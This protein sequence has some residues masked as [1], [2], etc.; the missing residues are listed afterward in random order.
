[1]NT[2]QWKGLANNMIGQMQERVGALVGNREQQQRGREKQFA[3]TVQ[4]CTGDA[5]QIIKNVLKTVSAQ[6]TKL[7]HQI[8]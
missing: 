2:N 7:Q 6:R 3:A 8:H 1:M 4:R 5:E